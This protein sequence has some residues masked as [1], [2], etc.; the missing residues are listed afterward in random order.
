MAGNTKL[1][2][3]EEEEPGLD[4]SSMIDV[5]FLLL[6][7]F[8]VTQTLDPKETDLGMTLPTTDS[9][10]A[11]EVEIDQMTITVNAAGAIVVDDKTLD[12]D[13]N[14]RTLVNLDEKL[15]QY[16][17]AA[18]LTGSQPVVVVAADDAAVGQRFI[19]VLNALAKVKI[20]NVTI[21]GFS[22]KK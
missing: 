5:S 2:I 10:S 22:D 11:S 9:S 18:D 16:K 7:Y 15:K 4:M 3:P 14:N 8:L 17:D 19:D 12:E 1:Q 21:T 13:V 6:I 20:H